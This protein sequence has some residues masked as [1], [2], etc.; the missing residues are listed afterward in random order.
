MRTLLAGNQLWW[1]VLLTTSGFNRP[2]QSKIWN[3]DWILY[4]NMNMIW[5][6]LSSTLSS[7]IIIIIINLTGQLY[8]QSCHHCQIIVLV[9]RSTTTPSAW[10]ECLANKRMVKMM[11]RGGTIWG[12]MFFFSCYWQRFL[13]HSLGMLSRVKAQVK[14]IVNSN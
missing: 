7:V 10:R 8:H 5:W 2:E 9:G 1:A 11:I 4:L 6:R 3:V 14:W 12:P 13:C